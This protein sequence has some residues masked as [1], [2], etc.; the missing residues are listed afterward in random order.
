MTAGVNEINNCTGLDELINLFD[1]LYKNYFLN[2]N[3]NIKEFR[4]NIVFEDTF[5]ALTLEEQKRMFLTML[6]LN[7]MYVNHSEM[8]AKRYV[9][10]KED[11]ALTKSFYN[12]DK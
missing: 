11:Q 10:S 8:A 9:I 1:K 12:N 4:E 2:Y 5:K 6:D 3:V 7:Q